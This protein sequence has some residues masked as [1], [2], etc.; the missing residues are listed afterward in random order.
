M[1][2]IGLDGLRRLWPDERAL[3]ARVHE[4]VAG[5][6]PL[7]TQIG[8]ADTKYAAT[9]AALEGDTYLVPPGEDARFLHDQP[10][11]RLPAPEQT[12][13]TLRTMSITTLGAFAALP[14]NAVVMR[15]GK[16]AR[17]L[18]LLARGFD[19]A[20]VIAPEAPAVLEARITFEGG[21]VVRERLLWLVERRLERLYRELEQAQL[22]PQA[23]QL[24]L[25]LENGRELRESV[26]VTDPLLRLPELRQL[27]RWHL[28]TM[29]LPAPVEE[30][31]L[32]LRGL[33]P[34]HGRQLDLWTRRAEGDV[35]R[36]LGELLARW[37]PT[38]AVQA[39]IIESRR[40]EAAWEWDEA[41]IPVETKG[42]PGLAGIKEFS[43]ALRLLPDPHIVNVTLI[44]GRPSTL[45]IGRRQ[46][47]I[48]AIS[49]PW[50]LSEG[51][52]DEA[53][54]R[55]DY[56]LGTDTAVYYVVY[57]RRADQWLLLGAFD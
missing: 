40:L 12:I 41:M 14:A 53:I 22:A 15:F 35:R 46:E 48:T 32:T 17:R 8:I 39:R 11:E 13:A 7:H 1:F 33:A 56:Q 57:D 4:L 19:D 24:W 23:I 37:G 18:Q 50:R 25:Q 52:W 10:I 51:W 45:Q 29:M 9:L 16:D 54:E 21:E 36:L 47:R 2:W 49:G 31:V 55:D 26:T 27:L 38:S 5:Y 34:V 20:R 44:E 6:G 28:E 42:E 3:A 30:L 43:P